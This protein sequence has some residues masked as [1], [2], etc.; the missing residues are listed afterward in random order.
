MTLRLA[1]VGFGHV[2]QAFVRLLLD[3]RDRLRDEHHLDV[4]VT[5]IATRSHGWARD[6]KGLDLQRL[7]GAPDLPEQGA[8]PSVRSLPADVLVEVSTLNPRDGQPALDRVREALD[9][10]MHVITANKGPIAHAYHELEDVARHKGR[11]LRFEATIADD[12]PVFN[13]MRHALPTAQVLS[14]RGIVNSTTNYLL[15]QAAQ[16]ANLA[17]ALAEAQRLGIAERDPSMDLDGWDAAVKAV[18]LANVLLGAHLRVTDVLREPID[19]SAAA[20]ARAAAREG[21]RTRPVLTLDE[22]S[23]RWAPA[24]LSPDDPIYAV[25]G[26]SMAL[27]FQTDVAGRLVVMLMDPRVEQ[28]AFALLADLVSLKEAAS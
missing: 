28:V 10:G 22:H 26:L 8:L 9:A 17:T 11:S 16:G 15:S 23:A 2:G 21:R 7:V 12:L 13:L 3:R 1:L 14:L 18:I 27:E 6:D 5:V 19:E 4:R 24:D 25:D 20:R